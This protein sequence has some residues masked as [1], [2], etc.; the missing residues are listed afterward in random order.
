MVRMIVI[1]LLA[2]AVVSRA[3]G[4]TAKPKAWGAALKVRSERPRIWLDEERIEFVKAKVEGKSLEE[5]ERELV[6]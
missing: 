3:A 5:I 1:G 6:D 2:L 4:E